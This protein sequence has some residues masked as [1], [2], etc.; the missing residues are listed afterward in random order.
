[1]SQFAGG[2]G[3]DIPEGDPGALRAAA[4][5]WEG[6]A[7]ALERQG[8]ALTGAAGVATGADW[9]GPASQTFW[10]ASSDLADSMSHAAGQCRHASTALKT[11][12]HKL[13]AAQHDARAARKDADD[14]IHRGRDAEGKLADARA[15]QQSAETRA[16]QAADRAM[17]VRA[18]GGVAGEPAAQQA[19]ADCRA[20]SGEADAAA[21]D[22]T[23]AAAQVQDAAD[24]LR[25][26]RKRGH[27][28]NEDAK[29]AGDDA[30]HALQA[31]ADAAKPP[32][33]TIR[34]AVP[35]SLRPTP[36]PLDAM[37]GPFGPLPFGTTPADVRRRQIAAAEARRRAAEKAREG[38]F[39]DAFGGM[40]DAWAGTNL[41]IGDPRTHAY[42]GNKHY[43]EA[44]TFV[45][46]PG[47]LRAQ[48]ER[49]IV[50]KGAEH[51]LE[52]GFEKTAAWYE[53]RGRK[54][55]SPYQTHIDPKTG[56]PIGVD[57]SKFTSK[58]AKETLRGGT[59]EAREYWKQYA[60]Q[61]PDT[62][63]DANK[64]LIRKRQS[65]VVDDKWLEQ[66]PEHAPW[67]GDTIVHHHVDHGPIAQPLP[68]GL[69]RSKPH[70]R[71]WH[72]H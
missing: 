23:R 41:G 1:M 42:Q 37:A 13:H 15:R 62:L 12:A 32:E 49:R 29:Q 66:F 54:P 36:N 39:D 26:A 9:Q 71:I 6:M 65:P 21:G 40:L 45:P 5:L 48:A 63:S 31:V 11:L 8:A 20:A 14:A 43:N 50:K 2:S 46:T 44:L 34:P 10:L 38:G 47:G 59:R 30:T 57:T 52:E 33:Q 19:D 35:V 18:T 56:A 16:S 4:G 69:H 55:I 24:D 51:E 64:D 67:K 27:D 22:A 68:E 3:I 28:A 61:F 25:K 58:A 7:D 53:K 17:H 70:F 72:N 60:K